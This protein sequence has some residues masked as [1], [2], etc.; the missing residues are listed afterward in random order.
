MISPE[1]LQELLDAYGSREDRW[2][3]DKREDMR[4]CLAAFPRMQQELTA[5][6]EVD[7]LL[8]SY[9]PEPAYLQDRIVKALPDSV[10]ERLLAWLLPQTPRLWWRPVFAA[11]LPLVLGVATGLESQ[12]LMYT[13]PVS[14]WE[15]QERNLLL[16]VMGADWY[17]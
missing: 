2:P 1:R 16:P 10:L 14:D 11:T 4:A 13:S 7:A 6:R 8:D 3:E 12:S 5:A 15:Q 17:E 9:V